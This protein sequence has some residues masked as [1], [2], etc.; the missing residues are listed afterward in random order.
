MID[1]QERFANQGS[2]PDPLLER[3]P[4]VPVGGSR[5]DPAAI[6]RLDGVSWLIRH[7]QGLPHR[8]SPPRVPRY[9]DH[10]N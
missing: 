10:R 4:T 6:L 1:D 5:Q 3:S 2:S 8:F 9:G 7:R